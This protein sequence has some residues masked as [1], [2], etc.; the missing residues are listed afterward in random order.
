MNINLACLVVFLLAVFGI[1]YLE[2]FQDCNPHAAS[3]PGFL[4]IQATIIYSL[5][6]LSMT[7]SVCQL[8]SSTLPC[9]VLGLGVGTVTGVAHVKT[10]WDDEAWRIA[11]RLKEDMENAGR[12]KLELMGERK[13]YV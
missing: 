11:R 2:T 3:S 7:H 8:L 4:P 1:P 10:V 12:Q 6:G 5:G 9:I 13:D